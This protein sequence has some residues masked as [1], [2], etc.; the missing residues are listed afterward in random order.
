MIGPA[1]T[2]VSILAALD[3]NAEG[4]QI[5]VNEEA[6][7]VNVPAGIVEVGYGVRQGYRVSRNDSQT[8]RTVRRAVGRL[9]A[10]T[11]IAE[12]KRLLDQRTG[13]VWQI[14]TFHD[15]GHGLVGTQDL[16][17]DLRRIA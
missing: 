10:G 16:R 7:A 15:P 1:N 3:V 6:E 5:D 14:D 2:E 8:P 4:D 12:G 17:V 13:K 11:P 9:P